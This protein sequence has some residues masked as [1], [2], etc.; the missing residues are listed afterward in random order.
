MLINTQSTS[1]ITISDIQIGLIKLSAGSVQD[2]YMYVNAVLNVKC[3]CIAVVQTASDNLETNIYNKVPCRSKM[4]LAAIFLQVGEFPREFLWQ[5]DI[6]Q[7]LVAQPQHPL[8]IN[9][10][11]WCYHISYMHNALGTCLRHK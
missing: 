5:L 4:I 9:S 11:H 3:W 1:Y 2:Q 6:Q 7:F 10:S 8:H